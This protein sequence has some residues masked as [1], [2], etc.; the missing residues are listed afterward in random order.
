M[1]L[2]F[3]SGYPPAPQRLLARFLP[4]LA[5]GVAAHYI[6]QHTAPGDLVFDPFG[7]SPRVAVE[8]LS[9]GRR[10]LVANFNPIS[11]LALSLAVRPPSQLELTAALT[12]LA[13]VR[14]EAERLETYL[15]NLYRATCPVCGAL[16]E[17]DSFEWDT[18]A[19][20]DGPIAKTLICAKC[21]G[22]PQMH[23]ADESDRTVARRFRARGPDYYI[24][25]DR[26]T[27]L[28]DPD[29]THAEEALAVYP[30]R[31]LSAIATTLTKFNTAALAPETRRLLSGLLIAAFEDVT[32]LT[33]DRPRILT[34]PKRFVERN[35]WLA[36]EKATGRL[37]GAP[38]PDRS[39]TLSDLL[40]RAEGIYA[41]PGPAREVMEHLPP[42]SCALMLSALPRPSPAYWALS[43]LWAGWLWGRDSAH[44]LR[45]VLRRRR[46]DWA[47][48]AEALEHTLAHTRPALKADGHFIGLLTEAEPGLN[49]AV[50]TAADRAGLALRSAAFQYDTLEAQ[51]VW[52]PEERGA[53]RSDAQSKEAMQATLRRAL[54]ETLRAR[55][56]P[57]RWSGLHF[58]AWSALAEARLLVA[59]PSEPLT[60]VNRALT[61]E[62]A[63]LQRWEAKPDDDPATGWWHV[64]DA[65][66]FTAP[67]SDRVEAEVL[68]HLSN[69]AVWDEHELLAAI[70]QMFPGRQTPA[71]SLILACLGSYAD[72]REAGHWQLRA[73]DE[74]AAR[75]Q[76]V[77]SV[78]AELRALAVRNGY[79]VAG[80]NPQEWRDE[81]Q[82][83]Y[84]FA[85]IPSAAFSGHVLAPLSPA[86][87]RFIVLPGGRSALAELKLR[88][89]P[90]LRA[91]VKAGQWAFIKF[92]QVHRM[93][94]DD[95][96]TRA[97]LEPA[98]H[99][100]PL[101]ELKQL[102]LSGKW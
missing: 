78:L 45:N 56:E 60:V 39:C 48:H 24:L 67:L 74:A 99:D 7:Q 14:V 11:R 50:L 19:Q 53:E 43:A 98:F 18:D 76:A 61:R 59:V 8:A 88:R 33:Q 4:P 27:A 42:Q 17:A 64:A 13:D 91:E 69:G 89:N 57:G 84:L 94:A 12:H 47:W 49:A 9:V 3:I 15:R 87:R 95:A 31:A 93:A 73:E 20:A 28:D 54:A 1:P 65:T 83:I 38:Q 58:G 75:A 30:P 32:L 68:R 6:Q 77:Q 34:A 37:A 71:R 81:G 72:E 21:G 55:A 22:P 26:V 85:A 100:D 52:Q 23:P 63:N 62:S 29:R 16:G 90:H 70:C 41:H 25:L 80:A 2:P 101:E 36:L 96:L 97:T 66:T 82:P 86:H 92:R 102:R 10:V 5:E 51:C 79:T 46:Y 40:I 35:F 44:A